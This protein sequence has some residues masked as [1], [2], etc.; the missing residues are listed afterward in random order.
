[1][2]AGWSPNTVGAPRQYCWSP[3][4]TWHRPAWCVA[5]SATVV[6]CVGLA[7]CS[8]SISMMSGT[9]RMRNVVPAIQPALPATTARTRGFDPAAL[10]SGGGAPRRQRRRQGGSSDRGGLGASTAVQTFRSFQG[11]RYPPADLPGRRPGDSEQLGPQT[12]SPR[13]PQTHQAGIPHQCCAQACA[14][15]PKHR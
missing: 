8:R 12:P 6:C 15:R 11:A 3:L 14:E 10:W 1:M 5:A 13:R 4:N 7:C 2:S 9:M